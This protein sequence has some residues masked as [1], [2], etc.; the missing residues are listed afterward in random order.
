MYNLIN[1]FV[2]NFLFWLTYLML[3]IY[4]GTHYDN[5]RNPIFIKIVISFLSGF[6][7]MI[8]GYW[9]HVYSHHVD[10]SNFLKRVM[11][12][13]IFEQ[14]AFKY[15]V[16]HLDFHSKVHH[17]KEGKTFKNLFIEG[18]Q[19][20]C[21]QGILPIVIIL[22][23][24]HLFNITI[25]ANLLMILLWGI[26]YVSMHL[27]NYNVF[28]SDTHEEHHINPKSNYGI[29]TFD[30]MFHSKSHPIDIENFNNFAINNIIIFICIKLLTDEYEC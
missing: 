15:C 22:S 11:P 16:Y 25:P 24:N 6:F 23:V 29:D 26:L 17:S 2:N 4:C 20:I 18:I 14:K 21:S 28:D 27:I 30:I 13:Y 1:S 19:N 8:F 10:H 5:S 3:A 12:A 7:A 9:I